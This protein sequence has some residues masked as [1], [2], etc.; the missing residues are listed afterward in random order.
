SHAL[1]PS[2]AVLRSRAAGSPDGAGWCRDQRQSA[3]ALGVR[4]LWS[5][6][7]GARD[8]RPRRL[9]A[10]T[11]PARLVRRRRAVADRRLLGVARRIHHRLPVWRIRRAS[12]AMSNSVA[13]TKWHEGLPVGECLSRVS[14]PA[15]V[16]R[17][18]C[19]VHLAEYLARMLAAQ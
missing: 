17:L 1:L 13:L 11:A 15:A 18:F 9:A 8:L 14:M 16:R 3:G 6:H 12:P 7:W 5:G 2:G 19:F 10:G 4:G